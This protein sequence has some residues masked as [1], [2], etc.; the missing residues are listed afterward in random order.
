MG[1][2]HFL[3]PPIFCRSINIR[4]DSL[5]RTRFAFQAFRSPCIALN[6]QVRVVHRI[7][8]ICSRSYLPKG[9]G[10]Q[11]LPSSERCQPDLTFTAVNAPCAKPRHRN[12]VPGTIELPCCII[13]IRSSQISHLIH[14]LKH[15]AQLVHINASYMFQMTTNVILG[16]ISEV[17]FNKDKTYTHQHAEHEG[18]SHPC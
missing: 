6:A 18:R 1:H 2:L 3:L 15:F 9:R 4:K 13:S 8:L 16:S 7:F 10:I 12:N 17:P 11:H 14:T 5:V